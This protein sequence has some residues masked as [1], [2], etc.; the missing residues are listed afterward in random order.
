[1]SKEKI[2]NK[3]NVAVENIND[4]ILKNKNN[5]IIHPSISNAPSP[6]QC[7][8]FWDW[9]IKYIILRRYYL[10]EWRKTHMATNNSTSNW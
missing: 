10:Y 4:K 3:E 6:S 2:D 1:M 8:I 7:A 9:W 5:E